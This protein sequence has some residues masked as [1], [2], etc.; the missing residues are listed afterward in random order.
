MAAKHTLNESEPQTKTFNPVA[1][2][3][4]KVTCVELEN[5]LN[6]TSLTMLG[7]ITVTNSLILNSIGRKERILALVDNRML[8]VVCEIEE[9]GKQKCKA[10]L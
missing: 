3:W 1:K 9:L 8:F 2:R 4:K 7:K 10:D 5:A 6:H